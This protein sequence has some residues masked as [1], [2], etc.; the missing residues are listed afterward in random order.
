LLIYW[1]SFEENRYGRF[2][3]LQCTNKYG[4][5]TK[6]HTSFT[7]TCSHCRYYR[8]LTDRIPSCTRLKSS[9]TT[10]D[11]APGRGGLRCRRMSPQLQTRSRCQRALASPRAPWHRARHPSGEGSGVSTCPTAPNSPPGLR[12]HHVPYGTDPATRLE[13]DPE[14]PHFSRLHTHPLRGKALTSP[15]ALPKIL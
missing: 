8:Y 1:T 5:I 10:P 4:K 3:G 15:H 14:T 9:P 11:S 13:R 7:M 12:C 2:W 6:N